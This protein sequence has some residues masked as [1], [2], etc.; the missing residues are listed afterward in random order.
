MTHT[1]YLDSA[2]L[3][4]KHHDVQ[5]A[6]EGVGGQQDRGRIAR[7]HRVYGARGGLTGPLDP[8][9]IDINRHLCPFPQLPPSL[10]PLTRSPK[11]SSQVDLPKCLPSGQKPQGLGNVATPL[12]PKKQQQQEFWTLLQSQL[13]NWQTQIQ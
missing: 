8:P 4:Q 6:A 3:T 9:D 7:P 11:R 2:R 13:Q 1:P 12:L 10:H 5:D